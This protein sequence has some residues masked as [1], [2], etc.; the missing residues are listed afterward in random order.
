M[1]DNIFLIDPMVSFTLAIMLLFFGKRLTERYEILRR[2]SIPEPVIGGF[3][4]AA[5]TALLYFA[6]DIQVNFELEMRDVLLLYFFAAIGLKSDLR[7]LVKGGRPLLILVLLASVFIVVQN[8]LGMGV[9][10]GFGMPSASGLM[11]GSVSLTGGVGTTLAWAPI[12]SEHLGIENAM[13]LG[14]ASNTVGLI[15]ACCIGGPIASYLIRRHNLTPS[16]DADLEVGIA[17]SEAAS[18]VTM[19]Y[20][21]VLW[22]WMWLNLALM[23]GHGINLLLVNSGITL[24]S[25]VSCLMAGILI[26]NLMFGILGSHR[27]K[28]WS[29]SSQG[30]ALISDICL[31]MFLTMALM[32]LQIWQLGGVLL[33]VLTA[34]TLQ[35]LLAVLYTTLIVFRCMGRSYESSVIARRLRRHCAGFHRHSRCQYDRGYPA[36]WRGAPGV[37]HR[38]PR[39]RLLHRYRQRSGHQPDERRLGSATH[40]HFGN[41]FPTCRA[42]LLIKQLRPVAA[43]R[44]AVP[45]Q[46]GLVE[47]A[48][49]LEAQQLAYPK[50]VVGAVSQAIA[51]QLLAYFVQDAFEVRP[52]L[53]QPALQGALADIHPSSH[54]FHVARPL[55]ET[56]EKQGS[57]S[58]AAGCPAQPLHLVAG[59]IPEQQCQCLVAAAQWLQQP[60][61]VEQD[62]AARRPELQVASE[63]TLMLGGIRGLR[64]G[65]LDFSQLWKVVAG[66]PATKPQYRGQ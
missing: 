36:T 28:R 39:L 60:L 53:D 61:P 8:L 51:R 26:R 65:K 58:G 30:M 50:K 56:L 44:H 55:A 4:C 29:G 63:Q 48:R 34:L 47:A 64:V 49:L 42:E 12:F 57:H 35:V 46:A 14:I 20:Y 43:G 31:G 3:C 13:E 45:A 52:L 2:Y 38:A 10:R 17:S 21:D 9:A 62:A 59:E 25:F 16:H 27:M 1:Q 11:V 6:L 66:Q 18:A 54:R 24:P 32:G 40:L 37:Y 23:L 33:F 7:N 5:A 41:Q 19:N 15:A 22:A